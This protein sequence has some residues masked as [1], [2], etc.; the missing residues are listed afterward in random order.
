MLISICREDYHNAE[1]KCHAVFWSIPSFL[2]AI[3]CK[4]MLTGGPCRELLYG[5]HPIIHLKSGR[6][7]ACITYAHEASS[8]LIWLY[9]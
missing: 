7:H 3:N 8:F 1:S 9:N 2:V 4:V 6:I 5:S